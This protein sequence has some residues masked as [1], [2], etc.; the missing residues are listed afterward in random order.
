MALDPSQIPLQDFKEL[1]Q[2]LDLLNERSIRG[3]DVD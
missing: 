1:P 3:L 2:D